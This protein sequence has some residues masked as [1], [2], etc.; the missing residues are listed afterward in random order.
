MIPVLQTESFPFPLEKGTSTVLLT[1]T[2][3]W[4]SKP[5]MTSKILHPL[6]PSTCFYVPQTTLVSWLIFPPPYFPHYSCSLTVSNPLKISFFL[7]FF[8]CHKTPCTDN[9]YKSLFAAY[10]FRSLESVLFMLQSMAVSR[11]YSLEQGS[12]S[13]IFYF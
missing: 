9:C 4:I 7:S 13:Y 2:C 5:M 1:Y 11:R 6:F 10:R 8:Y 3:D 12:T